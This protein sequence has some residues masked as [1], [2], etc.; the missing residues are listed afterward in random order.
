MNT[1]F[2][3]M[4]KTCA[5]VFALIAAFALDLP[6]K[7]ISCVLFLIFGIITCVLYPIMKH[8]TF[9]EWVGSW[10]DYSKSWKP[11]IARCIYRLW[12]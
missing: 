6:L 5:F 11:Y 12:T 10:Y 4:H 3:V 9:P 7:I 8:I 2:D 1:I